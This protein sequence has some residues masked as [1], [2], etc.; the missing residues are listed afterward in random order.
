MNTRSDKGQ[1]HGPRHL[2]DPRYCAALDDFRIWL[3]SRG[4]DFK[5]GVM[6]ALAAYRQAQEKLPMAQSLGHDHDPQ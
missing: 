3:E 2:A 4:V 5:T 1:R 6:A